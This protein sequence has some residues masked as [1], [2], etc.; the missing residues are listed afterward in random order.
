MAR[1]Q[2]LAKG[3]DTI[4]IG[5]LGSGV[6]NEMFWNISALLI[7]YQYPQNSSENSI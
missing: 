2:L 3:Y 1:H 6:P 4:C 7:G 5:Q